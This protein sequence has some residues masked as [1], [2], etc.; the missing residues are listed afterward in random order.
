MSKI[1]KKDYT[2]AFSIQKRLV[3]PNAA[4]TSRWGVPGLKAAM[5]FLPFLKGAYLRSP[6]LPLTKE[7]E[8]KIEII[9]EKAEISKALRHELC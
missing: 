1:A 9:L 6:L 7:V 2:R 5:E 8:E 4:V 3:E